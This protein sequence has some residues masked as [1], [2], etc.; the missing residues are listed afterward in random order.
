VAIWSDDHSIFLKFMATTGNELV[1]VA[2]NANAGESQ[3]ITTKNDM[4]SYNLDGSST[5]ANGRCGPDPKQFGIADRSFLWVNVFDVSKLRG[6]GTK[7]SKG[8]T[9]PEI[10]S[11]VMEYTVTIPMADIPL[12]DTCSVDFIVYA[13]VYDKQSS[14]LISGAYAV[15]ERVQ[16]ATATCNGQGFLGKLTYQIC[17]HPKCVGQV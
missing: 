8:E 16:K 10:R 12:S 4:Q 13:D 5:A 2:V 11:N 1:N 17:N 3:T 6:P 15:P 7:N 9:L 14:T